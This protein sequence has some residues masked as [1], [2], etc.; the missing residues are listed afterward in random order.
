MVS[1]VVCSS[2]ETKKRRCCRTLVVS[3]KVLTTRGESEGSH[4]QHSVWW[5]LVSIM[6]KMEGLVML[7]GGV[8]VVGSRRFCEGKRRRLLQVLMATGPKIGFMGKGREETREV[9]GENQSACCCSLTS[10]TDIGEG[11]RGRR[12]WV[13]IMEDLV[14]LLGYGR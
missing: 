11:S 7:G 2:E 3:S 14:V 13:E 12:S 8:V 6:E 9:G 10:T 5:L 1:L 4:Y